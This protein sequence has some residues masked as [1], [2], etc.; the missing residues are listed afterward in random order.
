MYLS[1]HFLKGGLL[2]FL[3][4]WTLPEASAEWRQEAPVEVQKRHK[5][6]SSQ[7]AKKQ[8]RS[9]GFGTF[10][11]GV[12][13]FLF[14]AAVL[15]GLVTTILFGVGGLT[16]WG[17]I[18]LSCGLYAGSFALG[19]TIAGTRESGKGAGI[20]TALGIIGVLSSIVLVSLPLFVLSLIVG[21]S[22]II[23]GS[24]ILLGVV[25]LILLII[26]LTL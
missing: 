18:A 7:T 11:L 14:F 13:I 15:L 19:F 10:L 5:Q 6:L 3:L 25:G 2:L 24:S 22:W 20:A 21:T 26:L 9:L 4:F 8:K 23:L 12:G 17:I 16:L 1:T